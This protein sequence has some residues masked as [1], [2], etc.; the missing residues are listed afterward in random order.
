MRKLALLFLSVLLFCAPDIWAQNTVTGQVTD[1]SGLPIPGA[2]IKIKNSKA[3]TTSA[4]DGSFKLNAPA[5]AVLVISGVGFQTVET[6]VSGSTVTISLKQSDQSLSEVVVTSLGIKREKKALGYAVSTVDKKDLELRSEGDIGRVLNGKVAGL[7]ILN[8]S[9]ISGSGTNIQIRGLSSINGGVTTPLFIVDGVPFDAGNNSSAGFQYGGGTTTSSRFLDLD[10]NNIESINVLKGLSATT[11]YGEA[12]RNGVVLVTTKNGAGSKSQKKKEVTVSQSYFANQVANL[13][14][15]QHHYG[16]GFDLVP[17]AAFSNWGAKFTDPPIQLAYS[18]AYQAA[19]PELYAG[20][21]YDYVDHPNNVKDFFRTGLV[22]TTSI[23]LSGSSDKVSFNGN[24]S[25]MDDHGFTPGNRV[26]KNN[27]GLGGTAKLSN[28][29]TMNSAFNFAITDFAT[30]ATG[31]NSDGGGPDVTSIFGFVLFTPRS[32]DLMGLPY[33][34]PL[35]H[36]SIYYR[37]GNDIENPRWTAANSL[38]TDKTFRSYGTMGFKYDVL[39]SLS[40]NYRFGYDVYSEQTSLQVNKGGK[41]GG[42]D[43]VN[44]LYRTAS[45]FNSILNHNINAIYQSKINSDFSVDATVGADWRSDKFNSD[46]LKSNYQTVYGLFNHGNFTSHDIY[47]ESKIYVLQYQ[48]EKIRTGAYFQGQFGFR[49]Y[50]YVTVSGRNDWISTLEKANRALFYPGVSASFIPTTA[51]ASLKGSRTINYLKVRLGYSTSARFPDP[52][53]TRSSLSIAT[54]SFVDVNG[55]ALTVAAVP[56]RLPNPNLKPE[57]IKE[58]EAGIEGKFWDNRISLDLTGYFRTSSNQILDRQLD[59]STGSTVTNINAG[60]VDNKGI[61][62][63]LGVFVVRNKDWSWE[64]NGVFTLNR[65]KV[66][67]LPDDI[68]Q[69]VTGGFT[70]LGT[71]A[72][73]GQPLGIIQANYRQIDSKSGKYIVDNNGYYLSSADIGIIGDPNAKYKLTGISTVSYKSLSFRMQWDYTHGGKVFSNTV[74]TMLSRGLTKDTDFDRTLPFVLPNTVKQDGTP[75]DHQ[76]SVNNIYFNAYAF[77]PPDVAIYDAT[78][79][80]LREVSLS[81]VMPGKLV[82]K[83][84]FGSI[85]LVFTG[86]N[87]FYLAPNVPKYVRYDPESNS[88]GVTSYRGL[89]FFAGPSARRFGGSIRVTF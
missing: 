3:G 7:D 6:T 81:F 33:E 69:I 57:L 47:D 75:N 16:G 77:G 44:G 9:G 67:D 23:N 71:F 5:N 37:N 54:N 78:L 80:R 60:S 76:Q 43:Y 31:S 87:L 24:Y 36:G 61:E 73:N 14:D 56:N 65:S 29:I 45:I 12:A 17:S 88:L 20:K 42:P 40:I 59:P 34:D 62:A 22:S 10:P 19:Y 4:A 55:N 26:F 70:N 39:K 86:N 84:P 50:A 66:H 13:P 32:V 49:D 74:R 27:F 72:K 52:Y 30:P 35:T 85:S 2:T 63:A 41:A 79:I 82:D 58:A 48:K 25:Y 1:A 15:Y 21:K 11:L 89:D 38:N 8:T 68:K 46:G 28:R 64:L 18:P 83:T 53:N 51:I